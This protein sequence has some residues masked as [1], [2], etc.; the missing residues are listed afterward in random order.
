MSEAPAFIGPDV[1]SE[2]TMLR[3]AGVVGVVGALLG[4]VGDIYLTYVPVEGAMPNRWDDV[5][6]LVSQIP[7]ER[8]ALGQYLGVFGIPFGMAGL[9][10]IYRALRPA[11]PRWALPMIVLAFFGY[12]VG[13]SYHAQLAPLGS[14]LQLAAESGA[15]P[16]LLAQHNASMH[17]YLWPNMLVVQGLFGMMTILYIVVVA[18]GHTRLPR[19]M[20]LVNPITLAIVCGGLA[21]LLPPLVELRINLM[22]FNLLSA[23]WFALA[24]AL[25]WND[26]RSDSEVVAASLG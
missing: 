5:L 17:S 1:H 26:L 19:W 7:P 8:L 18:R 14:Y 13:V 12:C 2:R 21:M 9:W 16:E 3:I 24:T 10:A 11:G 4:C 15:G 20:A 23:I 22:F 6:S 25:Q